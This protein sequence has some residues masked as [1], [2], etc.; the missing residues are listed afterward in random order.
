MTIMLC[1]VKFELNLKKKCKPF[2]FYRLRHLATSFH[3]SEA[4]TKE[5]YFD[6]GASQMDETA[7]V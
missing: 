1:I 2:F 7:S 3:D 4:Q 6:T 5:F